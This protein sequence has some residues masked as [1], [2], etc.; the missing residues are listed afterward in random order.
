MFENAARS[1]LREWLCTGALLRVGEEVDASE[2][3]DAGRR[4]GQLE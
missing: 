4:C 2:G 1:R 3:R